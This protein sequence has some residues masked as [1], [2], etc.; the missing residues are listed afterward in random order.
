MSENLLKIT[1]GTDSGQYSD[2]SSETD[3]LAWIRYENKPAEKN[4]KKNN[5]KQNIFGQHSDFTLDPHSL[6]QIHNEYKQQKICSW[7][8]I[9]PIP[10]WTLDLDSLVR[11]YN[12]HKLAPPKKITAGF[13][14]YVRKTCVRSHSWSKD[15][16]VYYN[17]EN[18]VRIW[19]SFRTGLELSPP[20][21]AFW[22]TSFHH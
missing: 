1:A 5:T 19:N 7:L 9:V 2:C 14:A 17:I 10:H 21:A 8:N 13:Q 22:R 15:Y 4:K 3:L 12:K 6:V 20:R 11:S 16:T 18:W